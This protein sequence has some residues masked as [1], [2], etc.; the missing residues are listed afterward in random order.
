M[1][2]LLEGNIQKKAHSEVEYTTE[3]LQE[4]KQ[5]MPEHNDNA[6]HYFMTNFG[7]IKHP[8][9]GKSLYIPF[10]YQKELI[11]NF[12]DFRF[13]INMLGRQMGKA[14]WEET[15]ILT[16]NGWSTMG[17]L[18]VGDYV[19]DEN[20]NE[21]KVINKTEQQLGRKCYEVKFV[22][23]ES[24]IADAEHEWVVT[25]NGT[26]RNETTEELFQK[27]KPRTNSKFCSGYKIGVSDAL[28]FP[29]QNV[30][31]DPYDL[32]LWLGDGFSVTNKMTV[33][34]D[35]YDGYREVTNIT[36]GKF[37]KGSKTCIDTKFEQ[38]AVSDLRNMNLYK[39][40]H[41]PDIY[42]F[43]DMNCRLEL[44]R[45]LMDSDGTV[46]KNGTC[47][48]Y[49]SD[50]NIISQARQLLSTLGI[51]STLREKPTG[52]K[53]SYI[54]AFAYNKND[55]FKLPRKKER[56]YENSDNICNYNFYIS[57]VVEVPSVP[58]YCITVDSPNH[59][60]LAGKTL[61]P[62]HNCVTGDTNIKI[63]N[64]STGEYKS[65]SIEAFHEIVKKKSY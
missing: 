47:R 5:C 34:K 23:G 61:V 27:I 13:N 59:L 14:L 38:F 22:H 18:K 55:I 62:T 54:L 40:K 29:S 16:S 28:D 53:M 51:K 21:T 11:E 2:K 17:E 46:E 65:I 15:P 4:L 50:Y 37:R 24:I 30:P 19:Y 43:N 35:D 10:E 56:Q 36:E 32:G 41:I 31:I 49:Q 25:R 7:Y 20:G 12:H 60:F 63:R 26:V 64:K 44:L 3:M 42:I 48:F 52:Y 33:H 8:K 9:K 39:N 45:G 58:V 6:H 1:S 57:E